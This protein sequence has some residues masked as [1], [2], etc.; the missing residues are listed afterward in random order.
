MFLAVLESAPRED[1]D[2]LDREA[3]AR[4]V[5]GERDAWNE[6]WTRWNARIFAFLLK[7]T[8]SRSAAEEAS[9]QTWIKVWKYKKSYDGRRP[10]RSWLFRVAVNAGHDAARAEASMWTMD[11]EQLASIPAAQGKDRLELQQ[12][13]ANALHELAPIDRRILL[14]T[15]EGFSSTEIGELLEMNA[16]TVRVRLHRSREQIRGALDPK[17][18]V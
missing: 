1:S 13:V 2:D 9:Q 11:D 17:E 16:N 12:L 6:L 5:A 7:R 14:L 18:L 3:M 10:F 8:G 4:A 15:I